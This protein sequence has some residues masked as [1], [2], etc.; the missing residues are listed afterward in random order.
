MKEEK[1][2]REE[3]SIEC[4]QVRYSHRKKEILK[5]IDFRVRSGEITVLLGK[6]GS[7]KTT[8]FRCIAGIRRLTGG[9][10]R[11]EGR[12]LQEM[13]AAERSRRI[14]MMPQSLPLLHIRVGELVEM[15]RSPYLGFGGKL[16]ERDRAIV[17]R[18]LRLTDMERLASEAVK[19][20]S[21][22]ERQLAYLAMV[23]AQDAKLL[24][25]DE[26]TASL[27]TEYRSR[28][29]TILRQLREEG[30]AL[31]V[32]MHDL[33]DALAIA[34]R[35]VVLENGDKVFDATA[36]EFAQSDLPERIFGQETVT[37]TSK[38]GERVTMFR[39]LSEEKE[40]GH[41]RI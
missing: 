20:L 35:I 30:Y 9:E 6:N 28:V 25:F 15:G 5:G 38:R 22:G 10:V 1:R 2:Q 11:L 12:S 18:A 21:G 27:D 23:L 37:A 24:L 34:D 39:P 36:A 31:A 29:Y 16:S 40:S 32:T 14:A 19:T 4:R 33:N 3:A 13:K 7:G 41:K 17:Q 26:P 8:L